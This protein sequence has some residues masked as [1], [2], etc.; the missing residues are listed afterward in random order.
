MDVEADTT[1]K[2]RLEDDKL[3]METQD[4]LLNQFYGRFEK[5]KVQPGNSVV[6]ELIAE[7]RGEAT[8]A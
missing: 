4:Q 1:L 8:R 6:D 7:R 3:V 5:A 2:A